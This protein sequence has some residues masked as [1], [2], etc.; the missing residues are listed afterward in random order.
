MDRRS[1]LGLMGAAILPAPIPALAAM[2]L[3]VRLVDAAHEDNAAA[4]TALLKTHAPVNATQADGATAL[5][6]AAA[7]SDL[8]MVKQL[9]A[10]GADPDKANDYGVTPLAHAKRRGS[11]R[12]VELL[13]AAGSR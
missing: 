10:A 12:M 3:G 9:L 5:A 13:E 7:N 6:W 11:K 4:V 2:D 8:A 1:A